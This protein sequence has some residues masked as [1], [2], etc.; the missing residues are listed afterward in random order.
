M[1]LNG[2]I[3]CNSATDIRR[4]ELSHDDQRRS[5]RLNT[6]VYC[7]ALMSWT[8]FNIT[9]G[10][11]T[12][13]MLLRTIFYNLLK[14]PRNMRRLLDELQS[15]KKDTRLSIP[16][17][18]KETRDLPFLDACVEAGRIHPP[19]GSQL[20][21][22]VPKEGAEI[23]GQYVRGTTIV[24]INAWAAHRHKATFGDDAEAW[25]PERWMC[26]DARRRR[27]EHGLLTVCCS[28][29]ALS[30]RTL[31]RC[32][33]AQ[34]RIWRYTSWVPTMLQLYDVSWGIP[35]CPKD[36]VN[37]GKIEFEDP[38]AAWEVQNSWFV[39]QKGFK[40]RL[41]RKES[42]RI[43]S[44]ASGSIMRTLYCGVQQVKS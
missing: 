17:T 23:C 19:F 1:F 40:V 12:A 11:D 41:H 7:R 13:A 9:A 14:N 4:C 27:M 36:E 38:K 29:V 34:D 2:E 21:R 16:V 24:G 39:V 28:T 33:S 31:T 20:E 43:C 15:A 32:G 42:P 5:F 25:R 10:S 6:N 26:D 44:E 18:W 8:I 22:I 37:G 35:A 30:R 3:L